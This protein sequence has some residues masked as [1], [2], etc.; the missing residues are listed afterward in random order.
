[1][2]QADYWLALYDD[3]EAVRDLVPDIGA[4]RALDTNV[5]C[6]APGRDALDFVSRF[7][8]PGSGVDEDPVTGSAHASLTPFWVARL[9]R[10]PL[11]A[12]QISARGG[13]L[14]CE[15]KGDRVILRARCVEVIRGT[16]QLR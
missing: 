8:A 11:R 5:I 15:L 10:N 3:A 4:L 6:T 14:E 12:R 2:H 1:M 16:L 9:G 13:S 7:F